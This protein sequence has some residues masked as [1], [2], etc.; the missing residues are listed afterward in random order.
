GESA[1]LGWAPCRLGKPDDRH[2]RATMGASW[3]MAER[4]PSEGLCA[5]YWTGK[6]LQE[7]TPTAWAAPQHLWWAAGRAV[8]AV[9]PPA[10][11]GAGPGPGTY[12]NTSWRSMP[13]PGA[14]A[15]VRAGAPGGVVGQAGG[16]AGACG[17]RGLEGRQTAPRDLRWYWTSVAGWVRVAPEGCAGGP[18]SGKTVWKGWEG[19]HAQLCETPLR[20]AHVADETTREGVAEAAHGHIAWRT[21]VGTRGGG[22]EASVP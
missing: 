7:R 12:G 13:M 11:G 4:E 1:R 16:G 10:R 18:A 2:V 19:L 6:G 3:P 21:R 20:C 17:L 14:A 5:T 8:R 22:T 9:P 15:V